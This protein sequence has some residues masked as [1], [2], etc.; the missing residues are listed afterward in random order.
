M[1]LKKRILLISL[2]AFCISFAF[3]IPNYSITVT[4]ENVISYFSFSDWLIIMEERQE[5]LLNRIDVAEK[6]QDTKQASEFINKL[7]TGEPDII[8]GIFAEKK[9]ALFVVEQPQNRPAFVSSISEVVTEFQMPKEYG[10]I[11]LIA[12][13]YLAGR[14]FFK[15]QLGDIVQVI[16]GDGS[17]RGYRIS[18]IREYQALNPNSPFS[19]FVNLETDDVV[20]SM[21]LFKSVYTGEHH[22]TLQTCIQVGSEDSWGRLFLIAEPI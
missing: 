12:H 8:K 10:V 7:I 22:L 3:H 20:S 5:S 9:F 21:K 15:L 11:G 17:N 6:L 18:E 14:Y 13:N 1:E 2:I 19:D 4:G 16:Y